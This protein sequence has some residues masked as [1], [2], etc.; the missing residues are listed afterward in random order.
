MYEPKH[1]TRYPTDSPEAEAARQRVLRFAA[2]PDH[3]ARAAA[4]MAIA[5]ESR[6]P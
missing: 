4:N 3:R 2:D 6:R 5:N 1:G